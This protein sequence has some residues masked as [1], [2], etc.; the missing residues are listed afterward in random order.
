MFYRLPTPLAIVSLANNIIIATSEVAEQLFGVPAK[1]TVSKSLDKLAR[2]ANLEELDIV[3]R[4]LVDATAASTKAMLYLSNGRLTKIQIDIKPFDWQDQACAVVSFTDIGELARLETSNGIL[5]DQV[6]VLQRREAVNTLAS[7]IA[8]D[9]N[10]LLGIILGFTDM[11]EYEYPDNPTASE[12][13]GEIKAA[14]AR[15]KDLVS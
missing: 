12:Y 13:L 1:S 6:R 10:N 14:S 15:A 7:G 3:N 2:F 5:R 11:L 8:H 4:L 9:F